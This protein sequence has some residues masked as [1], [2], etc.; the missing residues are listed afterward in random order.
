MLEEIS[1]K[2]D[3]YQFGTLKG[4]STT[5]ELVYILHACHQAADNHQSMR[6]AF[7]DFAKAFYH[8]DHS[9]VL[10]TMTQINVQ[11][12]ITRWMDALFLN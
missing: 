11:P 1:A 12:F 6:A 10:N 4:R 9:I 8:V 2:F 3:E 7:I 5:H